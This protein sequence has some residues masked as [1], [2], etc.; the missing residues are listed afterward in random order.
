MADIIQ[1]LPEAIANQI[2]AGEVIQRPAS[3]VKELIEN[4]VDAGATEIKL[5]IKDSGK[6][7]IQVVD[8]G[9]GMTETDARMSF[10]RHAT[11]KIKKSADLF[12]ITTK[13]FRGEALASIAAIAQVE[14]K[15]KQ[16]S[17]DVGILMKI[18]GSKIV[19]QEA[20]QTSTGA[21]FAVKN[22]FYN[23]PARRKFLKSDPVELRHIMDEFQRIA[24]AHCEI[25]FSA[26][27]NGNSI[28]HLQAGS[29]RQRIIGILGKSVN[30]RIIPVD[31]V[32]DIMQVSG[33]VGKPDF[34]KK[35]RGDQF[36]FINQRFI[37]SAYLTHAVRNAFENLIPQDHYPFFVLFITLDPKEVD[38]NVHPTKQEVKFE[39]E[40]LIYNY[41]KVAV[42]HAL[43]KYSITPSLDFEQNV[44]YELSVMGAPERSTSRFEH[45]QGA[46]DHSANK[47]SRSEVQQWQQ[48]YEDIAQ[49]PQTNTQDEALL[50]SSQMNRADSED[51]LNLGHQDKRPLQIHGTYILSQIKSG[52]I[53]IDQQ[54]AHERILYE[55]HLSF[56]TDSKAA[57]QK[58]LFPITLEFEPAKTTLL[59]DLLTK[60]NQLGYLIESFGQNSFII[61]GVPA[62]FTQDYDHKELLENFLEQYVAN[63]DV[64]LG[65]DENIA[66]SFAHC[67]SIKKG[68]LL[69]KEEIQSI[70]DQLFACE[71]PYNSPSGTKCF[72][73]LSLHEIQKLFH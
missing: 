61:H 13:G 60:I 37:K 15:T 22:L 46:R 24:L 16:S 30:E 38:I 69:Q 4:A 27:H 40:R 39:N 11:S 28:Y 33:Y 51:E 70:I 53:L 49:M 43:G 64:E 59:Q 8:N 62:S 71:M 19:K 18:E 31:E 41:I 5:I 29:L 66:K 6:T 45:Q 65:A 1:L 48:M 9:K 35:S 21:S 26:H 52:M 17:D 20:C 63:E 12:T 73:T 54:A 2:A 56:L 55:R 72:I 42:K 25:S 58:V 32:T 50:V 23:V 67:S 3:V 57:V 47:P 7:L 10:E 34:S 36:F 14:L 44:N 68:K